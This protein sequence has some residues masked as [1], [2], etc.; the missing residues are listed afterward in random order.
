M[1]RRRPCNEL[2]SLVEFNREE[3]EPS[4]GHKRD[5]ADMLGSLGGGVAASAPLADQRVGG[6]VRRRFTHDAV[7]YVLSTSTAAGSHVDGD[8]SQQHMPQ[9]AALLLSL[10]DGT[11]VWKGRLPPDRLTPPKMFPD[12]DFRA[13]LLAGL[14]GEGGSE[15]GAISVNAGTASSVRLRWS[16][17]MRDAELGIDIQLQQEVD[18][19]AELLP[20]EALRS[21]LGELVREVAGLQREAEEQG[22]NAAQLAEEMRELDAVGERLQS[23]RHF[24]AG[25]ARGDVFLRLLNGKKRRISALDEAL[26]RNDLPDAT[27]DRGEEEEEE[28]EEEVAVHRQ[29]AFRPNAEV[30]GPAAAGEAATMASAQP[31][32]A[33]VPDEDDPLTLL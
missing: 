5:A 22:R 9:P 25:G 12:A 27:S 30:G 4:L 26:E 29:H 17:T 31:L 23:A 6:T 15:L 3:R 24:A 28:E 8:R 21:L 1:K 16:A 10:C 14:H 33:V 2:G 20:G 32:P 7:D 13:R 18:L 11:C 19:E